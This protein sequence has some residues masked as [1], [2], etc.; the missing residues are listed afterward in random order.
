MSGE[1]IAADGQ[2]GSRQM[3]KVKRQ[4]DGHNAKGNFGFDFSF[5]TP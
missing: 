4:N 2:I 5:V 1:T 3:E